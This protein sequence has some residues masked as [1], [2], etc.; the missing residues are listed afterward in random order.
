LGSCDYCG[1]LDYLTRDH[2]IPRTLFNGN[3]PSHP[4]PPIVNACQTC[5]NVI[6]SGDD[7]LLRDILGTDYQA[8][9]S[10][11]IGETFAAVRRATRRKQ[12]EIA[13][14]V[15][16]ARLTMIR[17]G[18]IL[19]PAYELRIPQGRIERAI[20]NVVR[21]L[22]IYYA[23]RRLP[24]NTQ[25][26]VRRWFDAQGLD[27]ALLLFNSLGIPV[28]AVGD[29]S[30]FACRYMVAPTDSDDPALSLWIL[31]FYESVYFSVSTNVSHT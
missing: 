24:D 6:K 14:Y 7:I 27:D 3:V 15:Q 29:G 17:S 11:H 9:L 23:H 16:D 22:S 4:R 25:F 21:G 5:N 26:V 8:H 31:R 19:V 13:P 30:V 2:V 28:T 20:S 1:G 18:G 12:S 10:G